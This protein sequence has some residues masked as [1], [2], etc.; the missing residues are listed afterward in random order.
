MTFIINFVL[1]SISSKIYIQIEHTCNYK[2]GAV[3]KDV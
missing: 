2:C 1:I 3:I